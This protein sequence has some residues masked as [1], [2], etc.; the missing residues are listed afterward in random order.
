MLFA[1]ATLT[2]QTPTS[3]P[4]VLRVPAGTR[5]LGLGNTGVSGRDDEVLFYNPALLAVVRGTTISAQRYWPGNTSGTFSTALAFAGGGLGIGG[6]YLGYSTDALTLP[7]ATSSL[8]SAGSRS[9]SSAAATI[10]FAR[11][12]KGIRWGIA[13]KFVG[14]SAPLDRSTS[15]FVDLG[16]QKDFRYLGVGLAMQNVGMFGVSDVLEP[17]RVT[18]GAMSEQALV[19]FVP[20]SPYLDAALAA[21]VSVLNDGWVKPAGG[22]EL[23]VNWIQG[24]FITLRAGGRRPEPDERPFTAGA[25][26]AADRFRFDYALETR[27][28]GNLSHR[29]GVRVR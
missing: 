24:Y 21:Q 5:Y 17:S 26:L 12:F 3:V 22:L 9:A 8:D 28:G 20:V 11:V 23:G 15:G 18:I 25:T 16:A 2:A 14:E 13:T 4:I 19:N 7:I 27:E 29:V 10:G 1:A 6:Q